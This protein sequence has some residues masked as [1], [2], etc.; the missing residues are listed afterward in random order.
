MEHQRIEVDALGECKLPMDALYG[1]HSLRGQ[2]NFPY[3]GE[4]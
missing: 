2:A 3:S 1:I 4:T